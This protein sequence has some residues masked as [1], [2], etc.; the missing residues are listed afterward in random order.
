[1]LL[2]QLLLFWRTVGGQCKEANATAI[3][4]DHEKKC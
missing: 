4:G 1:M 3:V 2:V